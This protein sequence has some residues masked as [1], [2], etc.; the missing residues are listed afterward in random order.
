MHLG[1][2]MDTEIKSRGKSL[3][4]LLKW[5]GIH[6]DLWLTAGIVVISISLGFLAIILYKVENPPAAFMWA[7]ACLALGSL[8]GFLFAIPRS[9]SDR[10]SYTVTDPGVTDLRPRRLLP[11]SNI[12]QISDWLTKLLVGVGLVE[13]KQLPA[14]LAA[15]ARYVAH[16]LGSDDRLVPFAAALLVFFTIE[17]FL[18]GYLATRIIFQR[19]F[20]EFEDSPANK[21]KDQ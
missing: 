16:G 2:T 5:M 1:E 4:R 6:I 7:F 11:N 14:G 13:L 10:G 9:A 12:D 17:G 20:E 3:S 8:L 15:T 19:V 21:G 18:G